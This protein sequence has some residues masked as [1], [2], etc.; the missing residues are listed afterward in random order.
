[1]LGRTLLS[2]FLC[3][4][5]TNSGVLTSPSVGLEESAACP[6]LHMIV[7]RASTEMSGEGIIGTV[8]SKVKQQLSGSTSEAIEYPATLNNYASSEGKGVDAMIA[9]VEAQE[10]KCPGGKIALLGY[11]QGAHVIGDALSGGSTA[12][13]SFGSFGM[14]RLGRRQLSSANIVAVVLMGDPSFVTGKAYDVGTSKRN[15]LFAR[16]DT[17]ALDACADKIQSYCDSDDTFCASGQSTAVHLSYV[18]TFGDAA[19]GFIVE[20]ATAP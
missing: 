3:L 9:A 6:V 20:K 13:F 1:M 17:A 10:N 15:G 12:S 16:K 19:A 2:T 14:R 7:A 18:S 4:S 8:A 11:S 5:F